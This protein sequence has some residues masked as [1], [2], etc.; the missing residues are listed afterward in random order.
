MPPEIAAVA[1]TALGRSA[2]VVAFGDLA[3]N[4]KRQILVASRRNGRHRGMTWGALPRAAVIEQAG[5][6]WV[7]VLR[8]DEYLKN[9]NGYLR[10]ISLGTGDRL[11]GSNEASTKSKRGR[12]LLF[13]TAARTGAAASDYG[14][15]TAG[16]RPRG[17]LSVL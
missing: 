4:G 1:T 15:R 11:A 16:T 10:G 17:P 5:A 7:E 6:K 14:I 8:C 9:P 2:R 3:H 12:E 13:H